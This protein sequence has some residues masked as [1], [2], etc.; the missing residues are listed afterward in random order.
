MHETS[1]DDPDAAMIRSISPQLWL[2]NLLFL[3][4][5]CPNKK[6][7]PKQIQ[8]NQ[9]EAQEYIEKLCKDLQEM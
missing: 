9:D 2:C 8:E 3:V 5:R 1:P 6:T 7:R 4:F